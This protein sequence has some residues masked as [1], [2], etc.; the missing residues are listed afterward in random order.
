MD[1][2]RLSPTDEDKLYLKDLVLLSINARLS[3]QDPAAPPD[4]PSSLLRQ[5]LGA[6]VTLKRNGQLRGCIGNIIGQ[7]PLFRTVWSM[8]QAAAFEDPRFPSLTQP[9]LADLE[10]EISILGPVLPCPDPEQVEVGRHGLIM[11]QG[12]RQG[13]LLPQVPLEWG[14]DRHQFLAQTCRKAG[15]PAQAWR[16]ATTQIYWF[17]A[18]VF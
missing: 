9:E 2:F 15:L 4:P 10:V 13:L 12:S 1:N 18:V 14:W 3:G 8:A 7:G 16:D 17:E 6:F 5:E 11:R